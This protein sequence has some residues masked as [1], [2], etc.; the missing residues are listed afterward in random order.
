MAW[1]FAM[2]SWNL[3][4]MQ[5]L[6]LQ[7]LSLNVSIIFFFI[8][9]QTWKMPQ[10]LFQGYRPILDQTLSHYLWH[11][12]TSGCMPHHT[13]V[14]LVPNRHRWHEVECA[15]DKW[16]NWTNI[17]H[18][19]PKIVNRFGQRFYLDGLICDENQMKFFK[20]QYET[21]KCVHWKPISTRWTCTNHNMLLSPD[22]HTIVWLKMTRWDRENW[23]NLIWANIIRLG[24]TAPAEWTVRRMC[25]TCSALS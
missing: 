13:C 6:T 12:C 25:V 14:C 8:W 22:S 21:W 9:W 20:L 5:G 15:E 24:Q 7:P 11:N 2:Y 10:F 17:K 23:Q 16:G 19:N 18:W 3:K 1:V 4:I